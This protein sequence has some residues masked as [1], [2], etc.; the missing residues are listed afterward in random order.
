MKEPPFEP[1]DALSLEL[2]TLKACFLF[3][4]CTAKRGD[5]ISKFSN[6]Q[7][8][9]ISNPEQMTFLPTE[10]LKQGKGKHTRLQAFEKDRRICPVATLQRYLTVTEG[11]RGDCTSL[12]ITH[13][14]PYHSPKPPTINRWIV[15]TISLAYKAQDLEA[16]KTT[17][18]STRCVGPSKALFKGFDVKD[19]LEAADWAKEG[20]FK[21]YY[22]KD[23]ML[24]KDFSSV[25]LE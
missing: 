22:C 9:F 21:K 24:K 12:F 5:D 1:L 17:G 6:A 20:T 15:E 3:A 14:S 10:L 23:I 8:Y 25:V 13:G 19:I 7:N 11:L 18:H 16:P 4:L 2:L